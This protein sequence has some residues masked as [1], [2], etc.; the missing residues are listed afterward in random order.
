MRN[1]GLGNINWSASLGDHLRYGLMSKEVAE[2]LFFF[3]FMILQ[4]LGTTIIRTCLPLKFR[5]MF[6]LNI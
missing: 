5:T 3:Y 6:A 1:D 4:G 2:N